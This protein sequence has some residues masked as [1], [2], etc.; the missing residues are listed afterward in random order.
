MTWWGTQELQE[1]HQQLGDA[2]RNSSQVQVEAAALEGWTLALKESRGELTGRLNGLRGA[3]LNN[4][5]QVRL[6]PEERSDALTQLLAGDMLVG[7]EQSLPE[8][9]PQSCGAQCQGCQ[10]NRQHD[11][12]H[13]AKG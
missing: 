9:G 7:M 8:T 2:L 1:A 6:F 11:T 12:G 13:P 10:G 4:A 3:V 5:E